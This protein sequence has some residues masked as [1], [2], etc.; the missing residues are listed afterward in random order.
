M[1]P[2]LSLRPS[3]SVCKP[4]TP[5][6]PLQPS[7]A[8]KNAMT[9]LQDSDFSFVTCLDETNLDF[10]LSELEI[11]Q[12]GT[13]CDVPNLGNGVKMLKPNEVM[14][15][16]SLERPISRASSV[17]D[18]IDFFQGIA[19][20]STPMFSENEEE[21]DETLIINKSNGWKF[22]KRGNQHKKSENDKKLIVTRSE[23]F[24]FLD[25]LQHFN[26]S[27]N[28]LTG[29]E[30]DD[31][32]DGSNDYQSPQKVLKYRKLSEVLSS[33]S[34]D[35]EHQKADD[36]SIQDK[37][38]KDHHQQTLPHSS[39]N[40]SENISAHQKINASQSLHETLTSSH[41][42]FI[43]N[44]D[45]YLADFPD[46][47]RDLDIKLDFQKIEEKEI[48]IFICEVDS[49]IN[50]WFHFGEDVTTI[51]D[52]MTEEYSKL[53]PRQLIVSK[54]S[55]QPGLLVACFVK[56]FG[57]WYR[58]QIIQPPDKSNQ[59]RFLLIDYGC[60][61]MGKVK[62]IKYLFKSYLEYPRLGN[63]G[64]LVN[65]KPP[66]RQRAWSEKEVE[67]LLMK[68]S[69]CQLHASVVSFNEDE[70]IF[71]L[72]ITVIDAKQDVNL[73][74]WLIENCFGQ[75]FETEGRSVYPMCYSCPTFEM[76]ETNYP[77][78]HEK[79]SMLAEGIDYDL[80]VDTN[81][82]GSLEG[83]LLENTPKLLAMMGHKKFQK[84]KT[85]F[86]YFN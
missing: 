80:L 29:D 81:F 2:S 4:L 38:L 79:S 49:P 34:E 67:H 23:N 28:T 32:L 42:S 12:V 46:V 53:K 10:S 58:A 71:E 59:V 14:E 51:I 43:L 44:E 40:N 31:T 70:K 3:S 62:N 24:N 82:L 83:R 84:A 25:E 76:L 36:S 45:F 30:D 41:N 27:N 60:V 50:F 9:G 57:H 63:R 75:D 1:V 39:L 15:R 35:D 77:T 78:F 37:P 73:K 7:L 18:S 86:N 48:K 66:N 8:S 54:S 19:P 85:Y 21:T 74:T 22:K 55:I 17:A 6:L 72:D 33:D 47:V 26:Q 69:N 64:R 52:R 68:V 16:N 5:P 13:I 56:D 61:G 11:K 65:L 20:T